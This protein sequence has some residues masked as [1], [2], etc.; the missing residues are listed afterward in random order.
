MDSA[1]DSGGS[2]PG[3][4]QGQGQRAVFLGETL[5]FHSA[6][7]HPGVEMCT[8]DLLGKANKLWRSDL[9]STSVHG[10]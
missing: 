3:S 9:Q 8:D 5:H 4:S 2:V 10:E 1:L 7:L 6:S